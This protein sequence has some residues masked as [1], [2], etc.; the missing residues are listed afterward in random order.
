[1]KNIPLLC[2]LKAIC[3]SRNTHEKLYEYLAKIDNYADVTKNFVYFLLNDAFVQIKD[4]ANDDSKIDISELE[5]ILSFDQNTDDY[6]TTQTYFK[7]INKHL[8]T[9]GLP[10]LKYVRESITQSQTDNIFI[11]DPE[12]K[13]IE[14]HDLYCIIGKQEQSNTKQ[15]LLFY[16]KLGEDWY[17]QL[18]EDLIK[19]DFETNTPP[20]H[21]YY[22]YNSKPKYLFIYKYSDRFYTLKETIPILDDTDLND[23]DNR[24]QENGYTVKYYRHDYFDNAIPSQKDM[25]IVMIKYSNRENPGK[26]IKDAEKMAKG[27]PL[28]HDSKPYISAIS[29]DHSVNYNT[30]KHD[31][32]PAVKP[33]YRFI[34]IMKYLLYHYA[35]EN[36]FKEPKDVLKCAKEVFKMK[37]PVMICV[38][39]NDITT[40]DIAILSGYTYI[41]QDISKENR[42]YKT[43][44]VETLDPII[45]PTPY[46][47]YNPT[48]RLDSGL[49]ITFDL[50]K[51]GVPKIYQKYDNEQKEGYQFDKTKPNYI[52]VGKNYKPGIC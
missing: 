21:S 33:K 23:I 18:G 2:A 12:N 19:I 44:L 47:F 6:Y 22:F 48:P 17:C 38:Y 45:V 28:I 7:K 50:N 15:N 11:K 8:E 40:H 30:Q 27:E 36:E 5:Q 42:K 34:F 37:D 52:I 9:I 43:I 3:Y 41:I 29:N 16:L 20:E 4:S 26:D 35:N 24:N 14:S 49:S 46:C 32:T 25:N 31:D 51:L 10:I 1:M 13:Q 39:S